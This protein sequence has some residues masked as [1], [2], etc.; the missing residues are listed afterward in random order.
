MTILFDE[1][2]PLGCN[3]Q[4]IMLAQHHILFGDNMIPPRL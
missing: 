3:S 1:A 2:T 4:F